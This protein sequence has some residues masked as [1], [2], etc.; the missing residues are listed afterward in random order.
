[1]SESKTNTRK[2]KSVTSL[3]NDAN[4]CEFS[5][6]GLHTHGITRASQSAPG[7]SNPSCPNH[8]I[9]Q[10]KTIVICTF[11]CSLLTFLYVILFYCTLPLASAEEN[12]LMPSWAIGDVLNFLGNWGE[13]MG[14]NL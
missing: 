6:Y 1:M 7:V 9:S 14:I 12:K 4:N 3:R 13:R 2:K 10:R 5:P 11:I 8:V